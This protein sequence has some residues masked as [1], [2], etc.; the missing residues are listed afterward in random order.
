MKTICGEL[1]VLS[2]SDDACVVRATELGVG[3]AR[4]CVA[5][6]AADVDRAEDDDYLDHLLADVEVECH[7]GDVDYVTFDGAHYS[8]GDRALN[9]QA[10]AQSREVRWPRLVIQPLTADAYDPIA[11]RDAEGDV[12][13]TDGAR[14]V[15]VRLRGGDVSNSNAAVCV[16]LDL[17]TVTHGEEWAALVRE[18]RVAELLRECGAERVGEAEPWDGSPFGDGNGGTVALE[19]GDVDGDGQNPS[20]LV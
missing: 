4:A 6:D 18:D 12:R 5:E 14:L 13:V 11:W 2:L 3:Y 15:V 17:G 1:L 10:L 19:D 9:L 8:V 7:W 20:A 16:D